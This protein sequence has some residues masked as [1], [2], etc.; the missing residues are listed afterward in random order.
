M[1]KANQVSRF[2]L[3]NT[4]VLYFLC[5]IAVTKCIYLADNSIDQKDEKWITPIG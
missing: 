2:E 1:P 3:V 5:F 4:L